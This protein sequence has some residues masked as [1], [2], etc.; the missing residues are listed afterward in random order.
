MPALHAVVS[1]FNGALSQDEPLLLRIYQG[2][3]ARVNTEIASSAM[4]TLS[5]VGVSRRTPQ[6]VS[7]PRSIPAPPPVSV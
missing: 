2:R 6:R 7:E 4:P 5:F 1:D 3:F